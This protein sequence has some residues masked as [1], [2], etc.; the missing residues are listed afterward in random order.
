MEKN[1][2]MLKPYASACHHSPTHFFELKRAFV[3]VVIMSITKNAFCKKRKKKQ[4]MWKNRRIRSSR[5]P[6]RREATE[7][8]EE[9]EKERDRKGERSGLAGRRSAVAKKSNHGKP[10]KSRRAGKGSWF[11]FPEQIKKETQ[12]FALRLSLWSNFSK[13]GLSPRRGKK[14]KQKSFLLCEGKRRP[15]LS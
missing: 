6:G 9:G 5:V 3:I 8:E 13:K 10:N 15:R 2:G 11:E 12:K 14:K 1:Q 4:C 7:K